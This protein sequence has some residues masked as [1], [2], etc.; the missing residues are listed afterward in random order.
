VRSQALSGPVTAIEP[1]LPS[2]QPGMF[3]AADGDGLRLTW[4]DGGSWHGWLPQPS[5]Q[6]PMWAAAGEEPLQLIIPTMITDTPMPTVVRGRL[7][8]VTGTGMLQ[9]HVGSTA[10]HRFHGSL[11]PAGCAPQLRL[12]AV[13]WGSGRLTTVG[14]CDGVFVQHWQRLGASQQDTSIVVGGH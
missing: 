12:P 9:R 4:R 6:R 3:V 14:S 11:M 2:V 1:R 7:G 10:V 8:E 13:S 5:P